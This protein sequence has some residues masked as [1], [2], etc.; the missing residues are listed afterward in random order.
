MCNNICTL[1]P[2]NT[3]PN[4]T[5]AFKMIGINERINGKLFFVV[6]ILLAKFRCEC[7][8]VLSASLFNST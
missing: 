5:C 1:M 3:T 7:E 2:L 6:L 8:Q 4:W